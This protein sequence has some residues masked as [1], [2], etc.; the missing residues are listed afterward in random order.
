MAKSLNYAPVL[1]AHA[2]NRAFDSLS[3]H[4]ALR[5]FQMRMA[6][7]DD[8]ANNT[9]FD[10][11]PELIWTGDSISEGYSASTRARRIGW[12]LTQLLARNKQGVAYY[13]PASASTF[14]SVLAADW[15]GGQTPW[16]Y[17]GTITANNQS[18]LGMHCATIPANGWA[19]IDFQ[20]DYCQFFF[21]RTPGGS[22][23]VTITIDGVAIST[24]TVSVNAATTTYGNNSN[25]VTAA[26]DHAW[27]TI[28]FSPGSTGTL[29]LEGCLFS[30]GTKAGGF[31]TTWDGV[32]V[33]DSGHSGFAASNFINPSST[34]ELW[35]ASLGTSGGPKPDLIAWVLGNNDI[36][37]VTASVFQANLEAIFARVD[38][39]M[40][41]SV[42]C[43]MMV[44]MPSVSIGGSGGSPGPAYIEAAYR[45]AQAF[46]PDRVMVVPLNEYISLPVWNAAAV[47]G[48]PGDM[49]AVSIANI[50]ADILV[51]GVTA[52]VPD[53]RQSIVIDALD[54]PIS[55]KN[56]PETLASDLNTT[57]GMVDTSNTAITTVSERRHRVWLEA[58]PYEVFGNFKRGATQ[59]IAEILI[60]GSGM[61]PGATGSFGTLDTYAAAVSFATSKVGTTIT[62]PTAGYYYLTIRKTGT[63]NASATAYG[64]VFGGAWLRKT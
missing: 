43:H 4:P 14:S 51:P 34:T 38:T 29:T 53:D 52:R 21:Q 17:S 59:G 9:T 61:A 20:G 39:K 31:G 36:N 5:P 22:T 56:W 13:V 16:R 30:D 10:T 49:M 18:G 42:T 28:R 3:G 35:D 33:W 47:S 15:P 60:N 25:A 40:A 48:H 58:G 55:R 11:M 57:T 32:R 24:G 50:L 7:R 1:G 19:E 62:I 2:K 63:K 64:I 26:G 6:A 41:N 8:V 46:D 44:M 54:S 27:H 23:A 37:N 45:A 12:Q